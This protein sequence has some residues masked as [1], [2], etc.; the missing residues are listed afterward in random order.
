[1]YPRAKSLWISS[2]VVI[3][4]VTGWKAR[5]FELQFKTSSL[6]VPA[7]R[8]GWAGL[9]VRC[10]DGRLAPSRELQ[11]LRSQMLDL[12][13]CKG[14]SEGRGTPTSSSAA[15]SPAQNPCCASHSLGPSNSLL[16]QISALICLVQ[17]NKSPDSISSDS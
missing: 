15:V 4:P 9:Y 2:P 6:I 3:S 13:A 10:G 17:L 12:K 1:M 16:P 11:R 5:L 8:N 7:E 14:T